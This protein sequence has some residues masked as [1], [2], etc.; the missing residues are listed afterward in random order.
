MD[1]LNQL[2]KKNIG[3]HMIVENEVRQT[4]FGQI[5]FNIELKD[6]VARIETLNVVKSRRYKYQLDKED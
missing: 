5:T 2:L 3:L 4:P 6:G 1:E